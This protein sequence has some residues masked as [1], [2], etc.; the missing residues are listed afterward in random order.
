MFLLC[1]AGFLRFN[2]LANLK[3]C[4][5]VICNSHVKLFLEKSKTDQFREG[6]W[7]FIGATYKNTCPVSMLRKYL[8]LANIS[9]MYSDDFLF[10]PLSF[11]KTQTLHILRSGHLHISYTRCREIFKEVLE[12]IGLDSS[13]FGLHSL[14]AGGASAAAAVGVP[15]RLFKRHGRWKTDNS[16][17]RYVKETV[18]NKLLVSRKLGI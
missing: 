12:S 16:K 8:T 3:I 14:R 2:E 18:Q 4:D 9:D 17:D 1:Y 7:V 5:I 15:D 10:R 11:C 13:L 6:A